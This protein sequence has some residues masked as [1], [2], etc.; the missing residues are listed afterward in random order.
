MTRGIRLGALALAGAAVLGAVAWMGGQG[1]RGSQVARPTSAAVAPPAQSAQSAQSAQTAA[2]EPAQLPLARTPATKPAAPAKREGRNPPAASAKAAEARP[3]A[4]KAG[5]EPVSQKVTHFRVG[6]RNVKR[7][8][9]DGEHIWV[10][11][12]GGVIRYSEVSDEYR[13][14]DA[15]SGLRGESIFFVGRV[16]GRIA[17]GVYGGGLALLDAKGERW[18]TIGAD[19]GLGD[20]FVSDVLAA[21]NGDVWIATGS[22]VNRVRGGEYRERS[23]WDLFDARAANQGIPSDR[24]YGL[25][26]GRKG[27]IWIATE[28]GVARFHDGRWHSWRHAEG[29]DAN[30]EP[31]AQA[32]AGAEVPP[33]G[34]PHGRAGGASPGGRG[35]AGNANFTVAI[36]V[37]RAGVV[38][39]GTLGGGLSRFDGLR[40]RHYTRAEGLPGDH[41]FALHRD[42]KGRVWIGTDSGLAHIESGNFEVMTTKNGLFSNAVFAMASTP[43]A[44]WVGGYGG[45]AR[46]RRVN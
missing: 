22:G 11:T 19:D 33:A 23:R 44:I 41:V 26:E 6:N 38:W 25:A 39:A 37:D 27:E 20:E 21:A 17:A 4:G 12:S 32:R 16:R 3:A 35:P 42:A 7:I 1:E 29:A 14:Y 43:Q 30:A 5:A 15:R 45:L 10:A 34:A 28:G 13:L 40:W 46:I 18:E 24:V 2:P 8:F 31:S 36:A 9:A